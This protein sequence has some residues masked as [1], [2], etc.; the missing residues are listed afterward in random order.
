[1]DIPEAIQKALPEIDMF[2]EHQ[3]MTDAG[4]EGIR[5][6]LIMMHRISSFETQ[7]HI[8]G[9][10][11]RNHG[12]DVLYSQTFLPRKNQMP[13]RELWREYLDAH[14]C[15]VCHMN[16]LTDRLAGSVISDRM[17]RQCFGEHSIDAI[18]AIRTPSVQRPIAQNAVIK[19]VALVISFYE[20]FCR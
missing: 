13:V 11:F 20:P 8:P 14:A 1:M 16:V 4:L 18:A 7:F 3:F 15:C 5:G 12:H 19:P 6:D 10:Y 17:P 9:H 2:I